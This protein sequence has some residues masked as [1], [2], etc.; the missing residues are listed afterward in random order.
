MVMVAAAARAA[1]LACP[2]VLLHRPETLAVLAL[3]ARTTETRQEA[4]VAAREVLGKAQA[5]QTAVSA[6]V[7]E[8][9][10]ASPMAQVG[11]EVLCLPLQL[12]MVPLIPETAALVVER[13][14]LGVELAA[15]AW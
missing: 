2:Q 10:L 8:Q 5:L 3:M 4:V 1:V 6:E 11:E 7:A 15:P 12:Q 9:C 13:G 14:T